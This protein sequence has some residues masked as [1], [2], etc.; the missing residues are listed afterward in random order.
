MR[1]RHTTPLAIAVLCFTTATLFAADHRELY[2]QEYLDIAVSESAR[3]GIPVSI[4]LAQGALE[5][6][7]G[8]GRLARDA[9]N[10]F[11]IKCK[12][13]WTG[14]TYYHEDDDYDRQGN[15][16]KS[17]FR[18]YPSAEQSYLDHTDFLLERDRYQPC[19]AF[20]RTDYRNWAHAL[21][22]AGYATD[23]RYAEKLIGIIESNEL[24][25]YDQPAVLLPAEPIYAAVS[26]P[27]SRPTT[28]E[29]VPA[30]QP[31]YAAVTRPVRGRV[32]GQY[33]APTHASPYVSRTNAQLRA[34][35]RT[36]VAGSRGVR[37]MTTRR[38]QRVRRR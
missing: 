6:A 35:R 7:W 37:L 21:K 3:S 34:Q 13:E 26:Q 25:R 20:A 14:L 10:H 38:T 12:K 28:S 5:S 16:K 1:N 4:I 9:R 30:E 27:V 11:G 32:T 19:F 17:C 33:T 23:K 2:F 18:A 29:V 24:H 15:L 36:Y 31:V 22:K 8:N